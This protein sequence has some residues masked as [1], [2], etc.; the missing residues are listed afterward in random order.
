MILLNA[1]GAQEKVIG[2]CALIVGGFT[3]YGT[4]KICQSMKHC[5][6]PGIDFVKPLVSLLAGAVVIA[7]ATA[8][9]N[10]GR[11]LSYT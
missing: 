7:S 4:V 10:M 6:C 5:D 9:F 1:F 11:S 3:Y 8:L 2:G